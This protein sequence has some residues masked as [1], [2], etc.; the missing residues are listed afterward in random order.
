MACPSLWPLVISLHQHPSHSPSP[1]SPSP[2]PLW[3]PPRLM[4]SSPPFHSA[5]HQPEYVVM[6]SWFLVHA[7]W[8][9]SES[10]Q[11]IIL[12]AHSPPLPHASPPSLPQA[13]IKTPLCFSLSKDQ[14]MKQDWLTSGFPQTGPGYFERPLR[15]G[16]TEKP[17]WGRRWYPA[18]LGRGWEILKHTFAPW[19]QITTN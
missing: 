11:K 14:V 18:W 9:P 3:P 6:C 12:L 19:F 2:L 4:P 17:S 15:G 10:T 8:G 13:A 1:P 7:D 5:W 16:V